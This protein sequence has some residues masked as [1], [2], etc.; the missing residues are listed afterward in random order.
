MPNSGGISPFSWFSERSSIRRLVRLP[1]SGGISPFSWFSERSSH[2]SLAR[3]PNSGGISP[4]SWFS[5]RS[6]R[7]TWPLSS[8]VTPNHSPIGTSLSQLLWQ[9]QFGP[10]VALW[11][12]TRASRSVS[13]DVSTPVVVGAAAVRPEDAL[14][15][16]CSSAVINSQSGRAVRL[17]VAC[18]EDR[19]SG[20]SSEPPQASRNGRINVRAKTPRKRLGVLISLHSLVSWAP[21]GPRRRILAHGRNLPASPWTQSKRAADI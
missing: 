14:P 13:G 2:S 5:S 7:V 6:S 11:R 8:V 12:A 4:L 19:R 18:S 9:F 17:P 1:N 15:T 21:V 16:R 20:G 10:P 3:L